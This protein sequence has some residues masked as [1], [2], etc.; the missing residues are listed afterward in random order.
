MFSLTFFILCHV[1]RVLHPTLG[2]TQAM[3]KTVTY[4]LARVSVLVFL[5]VAI[6]CIVK[7]IAFVWSMV[8]RNATAAR[9][10]PNATETLLVIS[11][12]EDEAR[13]SQPDAVVNDIPTAVPAPDPAPFPEPA[14]VEHG[15]ATNIAELQQE[16]RR[17]RTALVAFAVMRN[18]DAELIAA[19]DAAII[20]KDATINAKDAELTAKNVEI[21]ARDAELVAKNA[22]I[23]TLSDEKRALDQD[24]TAAR[25]DNTNVRKD[26]DGWSR[27]AMWASMEAAHSKEQLDAEVKK[28]AKQT[29]EIAALEDEVYDQRDVIHNLQ[30]DLSQ[31]E[32]AQC[33]FELQVLGLTKLNHVLKKQVYR[34]Y[35]LNRGLQRKVRSL[36]RQAVD[37]QREMAH[38]NASR[39]ILMMMQK[40]I[41]DKLLVRVSP[42]PAASAPAAP[43][44]PAVPAVPAVPDAPDSPD[45]PDAPDAPASPAAP[46]APVPNS[47]K[48]SGRCDACIFSYPWTAAALTPPPH[49]AE[50]TTPSST[51]LAP[52]HPSDYTTSTSTTTSSPPSARSQSKPQRI[53]PCSTFAA[54]SCRPG[55]RAGVGAGSILSTRGLQGWTG[56]R[57]LAGVGVREQHRLA[58]SY[59]G[60]AICLTSTLQRSNPLGS[61]LVRRAAAT[62][63]GGPGH[64]HEYSVLSLP[65]GL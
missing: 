7:I 65:R 29:E 32:S 14:A 15:D 18:R 25:A 26:R 44:A 62:G 1:L 37:T 9:D 31:T 59:G 10:W 30:V 51:C 50:H 16:V 48:A 12:G 40:M 55:R 61:T 43:A 42:P 57:L 13:A 20:A 4:I 3:L 27:A 63:Q 64:E 17:L 58:C 19:K 24:L 2:D 46:A 60:Y 52:G 47:L 53:D 5:D 21:A 6:R 23:A 22:T 41:D 45:A 8:R 36:E 39:F 34:M 33:K 28:N 56:A 49:S 38:L 35:N 11:I 54:Q